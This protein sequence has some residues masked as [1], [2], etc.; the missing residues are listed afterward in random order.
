MQPYATPYEHKGFF[1]PHYPFNSRHPLRSTFAVS[2]P[3]SVLAGWVVTVDNQVRRMGAWL[4][5]A[6]FGNL[7][8]VTCAGFVDSRQ[9]VWCG[10]A[11]RLVGLLTADSAFGGERWN[12]EPLCFPCRAALVVT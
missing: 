3:G 1:L 5:S 12:A 7:V 4:G 11:G 2:L 8:I 6:R 9:R 10:N